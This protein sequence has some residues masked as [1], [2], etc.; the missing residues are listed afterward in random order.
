MDEIWIKRGKQRR[1][2]KNGEIILTETIKR[3]MLYTTRKSNA[4]RGDNHENNT[5][6]GTW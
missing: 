5:Y 6:S 1:K 4:E 2:Q 3:Y